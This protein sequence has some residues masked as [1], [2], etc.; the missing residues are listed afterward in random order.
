MQIE[1]TGEIPKI[2]VNLR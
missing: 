2:M 1:R